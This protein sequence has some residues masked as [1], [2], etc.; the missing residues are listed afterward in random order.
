MEITINRLQQMLNTAAKMGAKQIVDRL[1][2][3]KKQISRNQAYKVYG[4]KRVDR[5]YNEGL[6]ERIADGRQTYYNKAQLEKQAS[7]HRLV[8]LCYEPE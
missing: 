8:D 4:R 1:G 6:V 3:E 5:W 7:I 2:L